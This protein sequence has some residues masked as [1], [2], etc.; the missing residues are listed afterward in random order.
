MTRVIVTAFAFS[1]L[2]CPLHAFAQIDKRPSDA[3]RREESPARVAATE[4]RRAWLAKQ[5]SARVTDK[6]QV[7]Q[8]HAT[9]G[10][11]SHQQID[12]LAALTLQQRS[13]KRAPGMAT[14]QAELE[15][16]KAVR[17]E[18]RRRLA[19]AGSG[20]PPGFFPVIT[21]LPSGTSLTASAVVS[22]DRRY[23]RINA[24]PFFSQVGPV[25]TFNFFTGQ[26][27][28]LPQFGAPRSAPPAEFWY[29]G[30][31]TRRGRRPGR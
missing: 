31:R 13:S 28:R 7:A 14:A 20:R 27:R 5:L 2:G 3:V 23:V 26:T 9:L 24:M 6:A 29:D 15:R 17:D 25:D 19:V 11:L 22:P 30:F 4:R 8:I 10:G 16:A 21:W 12:Q 1:L 18:L